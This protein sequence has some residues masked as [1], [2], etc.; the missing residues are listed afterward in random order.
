M[1][2]LINRTKSQPKRILSVVSNPSRSSISQWPVGF[3][4]A[5]LTHALYEFKEAGYEVA[6]SSPQGEKSSIRCAE[7]PTIPKWLFE[8]RYNLHGIYHS[9][10]LI[11]LFDKTPSLDILKEKDFMQ[12]LSGSDDHLQD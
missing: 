6:I 1:S 2:A 4:A 8:G 3:W 9:P 12:L 11:G 7:R 5:K 10:D